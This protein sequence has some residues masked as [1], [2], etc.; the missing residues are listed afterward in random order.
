MTERTSRYVLL[1][2][3]SHDEFDNDDM[4]DAEAIEQLCRELQEAMDE[5]GVPNGWFRIVNRHVAEHGD[6]FGRVF[7][8]PFLLGPAPKRLTT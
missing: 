3:R 4:S 2:E 7:V 6:L 8:R 1:F 5:L